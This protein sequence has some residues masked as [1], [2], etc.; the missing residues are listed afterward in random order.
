MPPAVL[1][2][3]FG[4]VRWLVLPL[5]LFLLWPG[6]A[7]AAVLLGLLWVLTGFRRTGPVVAGLYALRLFCDL[8][9]T[10]IDL[11]GGDDDLYLRFV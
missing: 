4:A 3:R 10:R 7:L 2:A 9:G 6:L 8:R 1:L 5:P 11:H